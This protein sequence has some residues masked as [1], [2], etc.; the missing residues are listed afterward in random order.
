M[1]LQESQSH[2]LLI[3]VWHKDRFMK[4]PINSIALFSETTRWINSH[5]HALLYRGI[6]F[7]IDLLRYMILKKIVIKCFFNKIHS[8]C[9]FFSFRIFVTF[10][11]ISLFFIHSI[12]S[13]NL[14]TFSFFFYFFIFDSFFCIS[15]VFFYCFL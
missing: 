9:N 13:F 7:W 4:H 10:S 12:F 2:F 6:Q 8:L 3:Q 1:N 11:N 5:T 15:F 14:F